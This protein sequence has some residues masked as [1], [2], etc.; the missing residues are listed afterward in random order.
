MKFTNLIVTIAILSL[1]GNAYAQKD[2]SLRRTI[3]AQTDD[4]KEVNIN[5]N[6]NT[7]ANTAA[8][9]QAQAQAQP[10]TVVEAGPCTV[11]GLRDKPLKV[12]LGYETA[13]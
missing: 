4:A 6:T 11:L 12:V 7:N 8:Q 10:V 3:V 1:A 13:K 9:Q 2:G 5:I